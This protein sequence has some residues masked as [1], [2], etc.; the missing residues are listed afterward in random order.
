M[1]R[2][3][4][5]FVS[6]YAVVTLQMES[7][8]AESM[9]EKIMHLPIDVRRNMEAILILDQ[10]WA[11]NFSKLSKEQ[12]TYV[13]GVKARAEKLPRDAG[14]RAASAD[15]VALAAVTELRDRCLQY[16]EEKVSVAQQAH[17]LVSVALERLSADL[18]R[19]EAELKANGEI[20]ED[21]RV[22]GRRRGGGVG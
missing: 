22:W 16:A 21:V 9:I 6:V 2:R 3:A 17:D 11:E 8:S 1:P 14:L 20:T 12:Q 5:R 19:F 10:H 15:P 18:R 13:A 4:R 7:V